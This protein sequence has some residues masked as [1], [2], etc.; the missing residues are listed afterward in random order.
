[1]SLHDLFYNLFKIY[2]L[3]INVECILFRKKEAY[4]SY[5]KRNT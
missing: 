4:L 3:N 1:M 2:G 5:S